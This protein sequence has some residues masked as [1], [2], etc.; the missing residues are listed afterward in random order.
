MNTVATAF[1]ECGI[2]IRTKTMDDLPQK[3][4]FISSNMTTGRAS[5][6]T[7]KIPILKALA[8]SACIP[9]LCVPEELNGDIHLDGAVFTRCVSEVVPPETTVVHISRIDTTITPWTGS[10]TDILMSAMRGRRSIYMKPN[11]L[12]IDNRTITFLEDLTDEQK[13]VAMD[14]AY[15]QARAFFAKRLAEELK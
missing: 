1:E 15:S 9:L 3:V 2:D 13:K 14:D 11:T 5:L 8:C 7:G 4:F 12:R 10:L 6:L